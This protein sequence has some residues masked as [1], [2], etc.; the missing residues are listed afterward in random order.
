MNEQVCEDL[1]RA[2]REGDEKAARD[3]VGRLFPDLQSFV[4][5]MTRGE[6]GRLAAGVGWRADDVISVVAEKLLRRAP[7]GDA[8]VSAVATVKAWVRRAAYNAVID[9]DRKRKV[10]GYEAPPGEDRVPSQTPRADEVM[11]ASAREA[12]LRATLEACYPR[13]VPLFVH[14]LGT[15]Q[16]DDDALAQQWGTTVA[17]VQRQ[18]TRMRRYCAAYLALSPGEAMDDETVARAMDA[19]QTDEN[20]RIIASVRHHLAA[21]RRNR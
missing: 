15:D 9:E 11:G 3:A 12:E 1:V 8:R 14:T 18:R 19:E 2:A 20:R 10:R 21:R 4:R 6:L 13:G 16:D 5:A 7:G 17:N